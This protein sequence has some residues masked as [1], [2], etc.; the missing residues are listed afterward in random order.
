MIGSPRQPPAGRLWPPIAFLAAA[1]VVAAAAAWY[2]R[3]SMAELNAITDERARTRT[4]RLYIEAA[5]SLFKDLETGARGFMITGDERYLEPYEAAHPALPLTYARLREALAG[6]LPPDLV[7]ED[8]DALLR[9]RAELLERSVAA[10]RR[11]PRSAAAELALTAEGKAVMDRMRATFR[12]IDAHQEGRIAE[13]NAVVVRSRAAAD[14]RAVAATALGFALIAAAVMLLLREHAARR[15][16]ETEL[17]RANADLEAKVAARTA[18]LRE[19]RDRIA[20]FAAE[21]DQAV[22]AE[23]RRLSREVH[24]QIGQVFTAIRLVAGSLPPDAFPPGQAAAL[25]QALEMGIAS[26]RRITAELRPP[27][28]DDLGLAAAL[29]HHARQLCD[30]VGIACDIA[31][32]ADQRLD[33][34]QA[35]ALF[36]IVQEALTN[37][38]RH[39][40]ARRVTIEGAVDGADYRLTVADDGRGCDGDGLRPGAIGLAGMRE[41]SR[42]LGG[43]CTI[44]AHAG[45]GTVV[46]V[47]LPL[48]STADENPAR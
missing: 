45:G 15:A 9:R 30:H 47:R 16:L 22:E 38:L 19:A 13:L 41:R 17:R 18:A 4:G 39:A 1:F 7:W 33:A 42:L 35:L 29:E 8:V 46:D 27:L 26:T 36:R 31:V 10:T 6:N 24:D 44:R 48:H 34:R 37:V 11:A 21:Q 5:L 32:R 23:R 43:D 12:R 40:G 25:D 3:L 14:R 20:R 2:A 28:L